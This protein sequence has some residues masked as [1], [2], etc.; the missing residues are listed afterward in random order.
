MQNEGR[1]GQNSAQTPNQYQNGHVPRDIPST[2]E[3]TMRHMNRNCGR[4]ERHTANLISP[5][6]FFCKAAMSGLHLSKCPSGM[7]MT[8]QG[9]FSG[10]VHVKGRKL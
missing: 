4:F 7:Q 8:P 6:T 10:F 5:F 2:A 9:I 3:A 1:K